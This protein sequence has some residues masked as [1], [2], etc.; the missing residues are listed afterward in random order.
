MCHLVFLSIVFEILA[1]QWPQVIYMAW[2]IIFP[3]KTPNTR[4]L[5][6]FFEISIYRRIIRNNNLTFTTKRLR[7]T[8]CHCFNNSRVSNNT[9]ETVCMVT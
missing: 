5:H 7:N 3:L 8:V 6:Q 9:I 4:E 2:N 1:Y